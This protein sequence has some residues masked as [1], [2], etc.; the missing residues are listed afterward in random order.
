MFKWRVFLSTVQYSHCLILW[1]QEFTKLWIGWVCNFIN[2]GYFPK[3][4]HSSPYTPQQWW[5]VAHLKWLTL[6]SNTVLNNIS[7]ER[8]QI[9]NKKEQWIISL[10]IL[11]ISLL[12]SL[13]SHDYVLILVHILKHS[14]CSC[15]E[16]NTKELNRTHHARHETKLPDC[17]LRSAD[18]HAWIGIYKTN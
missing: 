14:H 15:L 18:S 6:N 3:P 4:A 17:F 12:G 9:N 7:S 16:S 8:N 2:G 1:V 5:S 11:V 13:L 10:S